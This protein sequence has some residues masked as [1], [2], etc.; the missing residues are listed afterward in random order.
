[1]PPHCIAGSRIIAMV[2][3]LLAKVLMMAN[4][5]ANGSCVLANLVLLTFF[6]GRGWFDKFL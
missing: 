5:D 4:Q 2:R 1:M 6:F 3:R